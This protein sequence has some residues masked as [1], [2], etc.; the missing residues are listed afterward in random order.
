[1]TTK[2]LLNNGSDM[3]W[4][5]QAITWTNVES[6]LLASTPGQFCRKRYFSKHYRL[7]SILKMLCMPWDYEIMR[8]QIP[9]WFYQIS[10]GWL[11]IQIS[12]K[13]PIFL[14]FFVLFVFS[15]PF[16][17]VFRCF[18][19]NCDP[20]LCLGINM[21]GLQIDQTNVGQAWYHWHHWSTSA[22]HLRCQCMFRLRYNN[23]TLMHYTLVFILPYVLFCHYSLIS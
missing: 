20:A 4:W 19:F 10:N 3:A 11:F 6:R 18:L 8:P 2:V 1:M 21:S 5:H 15:I 12:H 13:S 14:R 16:F 17:F 22:L 7:K 23:V 9:V